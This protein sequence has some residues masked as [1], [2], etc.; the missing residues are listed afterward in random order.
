MALKVEMCMHV[1]EE[2]AEGLRSSEEN[3]A[4]KPIWEYI[5][6]ELYHDSVRKSSVHGHV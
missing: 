3:H 6:T 2:V 1:V 5:L 4:S